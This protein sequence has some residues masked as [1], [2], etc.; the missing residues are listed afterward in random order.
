M[1]D[2]TPAFIVLDQ[3]LNLQVPKIAAPPGTVLDSL[4]Y[5]HVDFQGQKR[6]DGYVRY[7]GSLGSY[8]DEL[9]QLDL[10]GEAPRE[11]GQAVLNDGALVGVLVAY[12]SGIATIAILNHNL[13]PEEGQEL[14]IGLVYSV[15]E[16]K[17]IRTPELQYQNVLEA[18]A[19]LRER[20]TELPGPVAGLHWFED[21]L[22]AVAS[23]LKVD[24]GTSVVYHPNDVYD[25]LTILK[26][27]G[28][29]I[30]LGGMSTSG[31]VVGSDVASFF[32]SRSEQQAQDELGD[33][34]SYGWDFV[35]LGWEVPFENMTNLYGSLPSLNQNIQGIGVQGPTSIL[36]NN[37]RPLVI[38]QKVEITNQPLQVNGWKTSTSRTTYNLDVNALA[39]LDNWSIYADSF[40]SWDGETGV[41][42]ARGIDGT[43]LV[44]YSPTASVEV[45]V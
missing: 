6:I 41:V 40:F 17:D 39:E 16:L 7:D 25:G 15:Q 12:D 13:I 3:G 24:V 9:Y 42:T 4:N 19:A 32:Q 1:S 27:D 11:V 18:N 22:Y 21:R 45:Q 33:P 28:P 8:Q 34:A 2:L 36:G 14:N 37:G 43:N 5:E 23:V 26:V 10:G 31:S 30:Y 44:E 35:H 20:T 38:T 29:Y